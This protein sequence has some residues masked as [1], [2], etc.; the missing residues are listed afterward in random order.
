[1]KEETKDPSTKKKKKKEIDRTVKQ[2]EEM[3][4]Y[5]A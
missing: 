4:G 3:C 2:L 5:L 1:V